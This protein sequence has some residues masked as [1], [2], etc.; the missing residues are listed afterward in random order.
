[1]LSHSKGEGWM[2]KREVQ[3]HADRARERQEGAPDSGQASKLSAVHYLVKKAARNAKNM[4][5]QGMKPEYGLE[6]VI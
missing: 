5:P 2:V 1:M 6:S 3:F 4:A